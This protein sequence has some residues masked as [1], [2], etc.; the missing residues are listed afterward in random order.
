MGKFNILSKTILAAVFISA[1]ALTYTG[2]K[3]DDDTTAPVI[4][5]IGN[6][7]L[8]WVLNIPWVDPGAT[9]V[10]DEDG[11]VNVSI[12]G[13]PDVDM[14]GS[15]S[16]T[17]SA[18]DNSGNTST[19]TRTVNV[20]NSADFL[21][22]NYIN[23]TDSCVSTPISTFDATVLPSN[24][25]N[26]QFTISNFGAFGNAVIVTLMYN[27]ATDKITGN[28]PQSLSG[29]ANMT[30]VFNSSAVISTSSPVIFHVDYQ[31]Q[32]MGGNSDLCFSVYTK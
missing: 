7:P 6:N 30:Q 29:G 20:V 2:C 5:L 18:T 3:S 4:T 15:Y 16:V 12:S 21:A 1:I 13:T 24:T 23:A 32:D 27:S 11:S 19:A 8:E 31:W 10:D 14:K 9:A 28:T 25:V 17:Y 22:G 26:G